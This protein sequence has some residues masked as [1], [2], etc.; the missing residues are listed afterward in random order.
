[1]S[2]QS[3]PARRLLMVYGRCP[4]GRAVCM[5]QDLHRIRNHKRLT[6]LSCCPAPL[7][8]FINRPLSA[9]L[10]CCVRSLLLVF[11]LSVPQ[12]AL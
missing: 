2:F 9:G 6:I 10:R 4:Q 1:M 7:C 11:S 3:T 5:I 12:E 8:L